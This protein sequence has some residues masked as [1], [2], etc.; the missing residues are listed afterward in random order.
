MKATILKHYQT[1]PQA[2]LLD[3]FKFI[4]QSE[5]GPAHLITDPKANF[6]RLQ[7]EYHQLDPAVKDNVID[8][9]QPQ[10]C[11]LHLQVLNQS[12]LA[13]VTL[14]RFFELSATPKGSVAGYYEKIAVLKSLCRDGLLPFPEDAVEQF[15]AQ[16]KAAPLAAFSHSEAYRLAYAP[17][18]RVVESRFCEFLSLFA[19]L[20]ELLQKQ[21]FVVV[22]LDG[23]CAAGKTT[24]AKM[25]SEVYD[26]NVIHM[27]HFFLQPQQ[28]TEARL[29]MAGGNLDYERF[30]GEVLGYLK[31]GKS[32]S[33]QPFNCQTQAF[34]APIVLPVKKLTIV[35]GSYSHHPKLAQAYDLKVFLS[36]EQTLQ[37]ERI[38]KR[39]GPVMYEKFKHVW[40][41]LEAKYEQA[42]QIRQN[43]HLVFESKRVD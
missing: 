24:L 15:E 31:T 22:A 19:R 12:T 27:D 20:D 28:R 32:F 26:G 34:E 14:Q 35:E 10:L 18:Y 16:I 7:Q 2:Q 40:I 38:L 41:P 9:L 33:Y 25:L 30:E 43:S 4:H 1:Y 6:T 21:E 36:I 5:F 37:L 23:D 13:L 39:N 17:A 3:L 11:R 42:F 29:Q 8:V